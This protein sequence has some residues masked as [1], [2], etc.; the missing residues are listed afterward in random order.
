MSEQKAQA[1]HAFKVDGKI[2]EGIMDRHGYFYEVIGGKTTGHQWTRYG[3][4]HTVW[5]DQKCKNIDVKVYEL[6]EAA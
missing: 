6:T 3:G 4:V 5:S 1:T 2:V